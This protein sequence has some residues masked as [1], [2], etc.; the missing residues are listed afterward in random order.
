[1]EQ[2]VEVYHNSEEAY[3]AIKLKLSFGAKVVSMAV[4]LDGAWI[5]IYGG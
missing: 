2:T 5:V 4:G 1:M 3:N